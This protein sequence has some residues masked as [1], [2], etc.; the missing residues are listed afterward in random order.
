MSEALNSPVRIADNLILIDGRPRV[1]LCVSLFYFRIPRAQ[2]RERLRAVRESG[3]TC[4]D[5]YFPWN[6]HER[7]PGEWDFGGERDAAAFLTE[8]REE[9][10][11]VLARPGPYICSEWDGGGLPA[12]LSLIDGLRLRDNEP[13][14]LEQVRAWYDRI[15]PILCEHQYGAGGAVIAIQLENELDF[16]PCTDPAGY[17]TA[18]RD[19]ALA[20]DIEVPLIACAGQGDVPRATGRVPGVLPAV[21]LYPDDDA[22]GI[23]ALT[24]AYRDEVGRDGT[25]LCVTETNRAHRTLRRMLSCG[26]RMLGPYLQASGVDFGFTTAVNNWGS[27]LALLTSDYDFGGY[28]SPTGSARPEHAEGRLLAGLVDALGPALA[29]ARPGTAPRVEAG[30]PLP[31]GGARALLLDG[32]GTLVSLPNLGGEAGTATIT[33]GDREIS[34]TVPTGRCPFVLFDLP[35]H[36]YGL[37]GTLLYSTAEPIAVRMEET[38][39]TLALHA[40]AP[41]EVLPALGPGVT[42]TAAGLTVGGDDPLQLSY[43]SGIGTAT[44]TA[45]A[46]PPLHLVI[47]G[48]ED[49]SRLRGLTADG[50]PIFASPGEATPSATPRTAEPPLPLLATG[51]VPVLE[52]AGD[53]VSLT[54]P[55]HLERAGI[56]RGFAW[57]TAPAA[58]AVSEPIALLLHDAA[59]ILSVYL[60]GTYQGTVVPGGGTAL[61]PVT[62]A[63]TAAP[64]L[65]IRA[66]IWGHSNFHDIRLP[67]LHIGAMRGLRAVTAVTAVHDLSAGWRLTS[68]DGQVPEFPPVTGPGGWISAANPSVCRYR[69][70]L[71]ALAE[72]ERAVLRWKGLQAQVRV[73]VNGMELGTVNPHD[74]YLDITAALR[75]GHAGVA[76]L[77][78]TRWHGAEPGTLTLLIGRNVTDLRVR[79]AEEP[80]LAAAAITIRARARP[81]EL[82]WR[83]AAG[84]TRWLFIDV[85]ALAGADWTIRCHGGNAKLT[86][87]FG[88]RVVGRV[89]LPSASRPDLKGGEGDLLVL[90]D[91]WFADAGATVAVL[92]EAVDGDATLTSIEPLLG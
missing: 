14:Y 37:P 19:M 25:P 73:E 45:A 64:S 91:P 46:G 6:H 70:E 58:A 1:V 84:E 61:L 39:V 72:S 77:V 44:L 40:D 69:R 30:F 83:L 63:D 92:V 80:E 5:V 47:L 29:A 24:E 62:T 68:I 35:L 85:A 67:A 4:V 54:E 27:P 22:P 71:P 8:A 13:R 76:E 28:L 15:L 48:T 79:G 81:V 7:A 42:V 11:L 43:E 65:L 20:H 16:Y 21:N 86:A 56:Y 9:G 26:A 33:W 51:P 3:Y 17:L 74:P 12:W 18:L 53:G 60:D 38:S 59:D 2:W 31:E 23:E 89:W 10:L 75:P 50:R 57:Y 32:G 52:Q 78:V 82:P 34:R 55:A 88:G 41:A 90:P 36:T 66:E 87:L 49:A